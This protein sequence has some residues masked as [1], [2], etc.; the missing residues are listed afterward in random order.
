MHIFVCFMHA[1]ALTLS[2][3]LHLSGV[4]GIVIGRGPGMCD[5]QSGEVPGYMT[6][7]RENSP[8][9]VTQVRREGADVFGK[10][11]AARK[12]DYDRSAQEPA[13]RASICTGEQV[14][15][16]RDRRSGRFEEVM[17]IRDEGDLAEF[18][19]QYGIEG[20]IAKFY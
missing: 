10:K 1:F 7:G 16:F 18:K 15:G 20:D 3:H 12:M 13:I 11:K 8:G 2:R 17:L 5:L 6:C 14:A 19:R 4:C 9:C